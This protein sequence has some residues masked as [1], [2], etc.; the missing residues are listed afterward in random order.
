MQI[1]VGTTITGTRDNSLD[2]SRTTKL[3][4]TP[5]ERPEIVPATRALTLNE[6]QGPGGPLAVLVNNSMWDLDV[7][8]TPAV[9]ST[10]VWEII[11]LTADTH[12]I[13]LHLVQFQLLDRQAFNT[14]KYGKVYG[15]PEP[16]DGPPLPYATRNAMTGLKLGGNPDV[17]AYRSGPVFAPDVNETGWKDTFRMNPGEVTRVL[18]R[19]APQNAT[20]KL[21][22]PVLPGQNL[23]PFNP[24]AVMG[25]ANDGFGFPGG[26]GYVWHCH[27]VDHEDNEMMRPMRIVM[28]PPGVALNR[29]VTAEG[30]PAATSVR[31]GDAF[32]NPSRNVTRLGFTLPQ[33]MNVELAVYDIAGREV[34]RLASGLYPAGENSVVWNGTDGAGRAL[35][36]GAYLYRLEAGGMQFIRKMVIVR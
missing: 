35:P 4:T 29:S 33:A 3:R 31:L 21:G 30:E 34:G 15:D 1:R 6:N 12:P 24:T 8:E 23:Y 16:G 18:V 2:P 20:A 22:H 36:A 7:S 13:H 17:T 19:V 28:P 27:I 26:P 11:N 9:G 32:P 5:I 10:E 14:S 25:V